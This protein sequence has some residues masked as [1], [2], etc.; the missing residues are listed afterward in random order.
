MTTFVQIESPDGEIG[1]CSERALPI[2]EAKGYKL[3]IPVAEDVKGPANTEPVAPVPPTD[4]EIAQRILDGEAEGVTLFDPTEHTVAEILDHL[5]TADAVEFARVIDAESAGKARKSVISPR[6]SAPIVPAQT[7]VTAT[8]D[9]EGNDD[10]DSTAGDDA[11][12]QQVDVDPAV[13]D[14]DPS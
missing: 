8:P 2:W 1:S 5:A 11:E 3:H 6:T 14:S 13:P 7:T 9:H 10:G 4:I 12:Q